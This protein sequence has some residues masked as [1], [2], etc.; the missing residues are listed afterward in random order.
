MVRELQQREIALVDAPSLDDLDQVLQAADIVQLHFWNSPVTWEFLRREAPPMRL[1]MWSHV[2]GA[3]PPHVLPDELGD[4]ADRLVVST[5]FSLIERPDTTLIEAFT[6]P[7]RVAAK[8]AERPSLP[9][10]GFVGSLDAVKIHPAYVELHVP[11][12]TSGARVIVCGDGDARPG[13]QAA[14]ARAGD[15]FDWRGYVFDIGAALAEMDVFGYPVHPTFGEASELVLQEAMLAGVPPVV[16]ASAGARH[17]V[18]D[19]VTGIV[20][21]DEQSYV[22]AVRRLLHDEDLRNRLG[23][24]ARARGAVRWGSERIADQ[25]RRLYAEMID[26]PKRQASRP[27][28]DRAG[29]QLFTASLGGHAAPFVAS[30]TA[31]DPVAASDADDAISGL[32]EQLTGRGEGGILHYSAHY[33]DDPLLHLWAGLALA[34]RGRHALA[35]SEFHRAR[36]AGLDERRLHRYLPEWTTHG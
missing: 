15:G 29:W 18:E 11:L 34:G 21:A 10:V 2:G 36:A 8:P 20:V 32:G 17:T 35:A 22:H 16:L 12:I 14:A 33:P 25:W 5:P 6:E 3:H 9:T 23:S 4:R 24:A 1:A 27:P 31:A 13:M 30:A 28:G 26:E 7:S 19:G